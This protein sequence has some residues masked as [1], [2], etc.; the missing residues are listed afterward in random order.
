MK[1]CLSLLLPVVIYCLLPLNTLHAQG[2]TILENEFSYSA[3]FNYNSNPSSRDYYTN[4]II[5]EIAKSIPKRVEYTSFSVS[6]VMR[7]KLIKLDSMHYKLTAELKN[8]TAAG[9]IFYKGINVSKVLVPGEF[10]FTV[11]VFRKTGGIPTNSGNQIQILYQNYQAIRL[12]DNMGYFPILDMPFADTI[13][14]G[15]YSVLF[16][17]QKLFYNEASKIRFFEFMTYINDYYA[18][19]NQISQALQKVQ[20]V[21]LNN[22]DMLSFYDIELREAE[23][24]IASIESR[25]FPLNLNL[26]DNDPMHFMD[27]MGSLT[28]QAR[29]TR[30]QLNQKLSILD[31]LYYQQGND[32]LAQ[33]KITDAINYYN[34]SLQVNPFF[35]PAQYQLAR[36]EF[37]SGNFSK[38]AA[39]V[40]YALLKMNP[41]PSTQQLL[42]QLA[43]T[44]YSTLI[45][46]GSRLISTQNYNE[47]IAAL[48]EARKLCTSTPGLVCTE[49]LSKKM[50]E[51]KYGMYQSFLTVADKAL[52]NNQLNIAETYI[53]Q[54]LDYQRQNAT[55]IINGLESEKMF[56][57][58]CN[59]WI[60]KGQSLNVS[61]QFENALKAFT[62]AD[63]IVKV[64]PSVQTVIGIKE[65]Y[66]TARRGIYQNKLMDGRK[67]MEQGKLDEAELKVNNAIAFA[68]QYPE[69]ITDTREASKLMTEIKS[70]QYNNLIAS[71]QQKLRGENYD[72]AL[73]DFMAAKTIE[74]QYS[75]RK[76]DSLVIYIRMSAKP[77]VMNTIKT[78][79]TKAWGNDLAAAQNC[80]QT[81]MAD[82]QSYGLE[83]DA[84]IIRE[85]EL[86]KG[87]IF[88]QECTNASNAYN[89]HIA[90]AQK[91]ER[92]LQFINADEYLNRALT[93]ASEKPLC[94]IDNRAA[95]NERLRIRSAIDYQRQMQEVGALRTKQNFGQAITSYNLAGQYYAANRIDTF[96]L[97]HLD[98][99]SFIIS[100]QDVNFLY[101][102][103]D[104]MLNSK[105]Y[106]Q[107][108]V[109]L[110]ELMKKNYPVNYTKTLQT[111]LATKLAIRDKVANPGSDYKINI[112]KYT[113][114]E[115]WLKTFTKAY[116]KAWKKN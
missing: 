93:V 66:T 83:K 81:A 53:N 33:N 92:D 84:D 57:R 110:K 3:S 6:Y 78:G 52:Q 54:S 40:N 42:V 101:F 114:G 113:E 64:Y 109:L 99:L 115:V 50:A 82:Q 56:A 86:L 108:L 45:D 79:Q 2:T 89:D 15:V 106:D 111:S 97:K 11:K 14:D 104:F 76:N 5:Q 32:L 74:Q 61:F 102:G 70:N 96:G 16:E 26:H 67:S 75:F 22:V 112:L 29:Q 48:E 10:D 23:N 9:D 51:A 94:A 95:I 65:G 103:A 35:A 55:E 98:L 91:A 46:E 85:L 88:T 87:K 12:T 28:D 18:S 17:N 27:K 62:K 1:K 24:I 49:A 68:Q 31:Q 100:C 77:L 60:A 116:K 13:K 37:N 69:D 25:N 44:I 34:K 59:A 105:E 30:F 38:A 43:N 4:I 72:P 19:D 41:D 90:N 58:L 71:G 39:M 47:A 73:K 21:N 8:F 80:Y 20:S 63:S 7:H 36:I 107:S